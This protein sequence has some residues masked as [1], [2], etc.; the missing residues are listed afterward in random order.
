MPAIGAELC[1]VVITVGERNRPAIEAA[2]RAQPAN[3][4]QLKHV[5]GLF[6]SSYDIGPGDVACDDGCSSRHECRAIGP[7]AAQPRLKHLDATGCAPRLAFRRSTTA[8][9]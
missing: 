9:I 6:D 4:L 3:R 7:Q 2:L 5:R 8:S 1:W